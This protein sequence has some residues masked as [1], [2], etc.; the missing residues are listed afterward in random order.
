MLLHAFI[1][2]QVEFFKCY[3]VSILLV[4]TY[5]CYDDC[6]FGYCGHF[7]LVRI[8]L[9]NPCLMCDWMVVIY[10]CFTYTNTLYTSVWYEWVKYVCKHNMIITNVCVSGDE[11][12][13]G[14]GTSFLCSCGS[15][16]YVLYSYYLFLIVSLHSKISTLWFSIYD[17]V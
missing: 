14:F 2:F 5:K 13:H 10:E 11:I 4:V 17:W 9:F 16:V 12:S 8:I 6:R 7:L 1:N 3:L 15:L